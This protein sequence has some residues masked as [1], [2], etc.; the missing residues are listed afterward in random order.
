M[1]WIGLAAVESI[2]NIDHSQGR[3]CGGPGETIPLLALTSVIRLDGDDDD[4]NDDGGGHDAAADG[5]GGD[6]DADDN[7]KEVEVVHSSTAADTCD[8]S[9][10]FSSHI[11][12]SVGS[13]QGYL[14]HTGDYKELLRFN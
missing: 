5:D 10:V 9:Y 4:G 3:G 13:V 11:L 12:V 7:E 14:R 6:D 1:G 2:T 8:T